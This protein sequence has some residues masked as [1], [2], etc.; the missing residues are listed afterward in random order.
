MQVFINFWC[1]DVVVVQFAS[2]LARVL[3]LWNETF[4]DDTSVFFIFSPIC[5]A[6]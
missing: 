2:E 3:G 5:V 4:A 6:S 1:A